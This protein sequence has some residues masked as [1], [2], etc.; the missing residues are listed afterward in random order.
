MHLTLNFYPASCN[1]STQPCQKLYIGIQANRSPAYTLSHTAAPVS[2]RHP[3][4]NWRSDTKTVQ[5]LPAQLQLFTRLCTH[6]P[7]K[8]VVKARSSELCGGASHRRLASR[9]AIIHTFLPRTLS[10]CTGSLSHSHKQFLKGCWQCGAL[11]GPE[12]WEWH[13]PL[14]QGRVLGR[15]LRALCKS[16]GTTCGC[17]PGQVP[18]CSEGSAAHAGSQATPAHARAQL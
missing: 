14:P 4:G 18:G 12:L 10:V 6:A 13:L 8:S 7:I 1:L 5:A 9:A 11:R 2:A 16:A 15:Q 3:A 17:T